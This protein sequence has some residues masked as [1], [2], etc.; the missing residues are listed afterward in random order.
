MTTFGSRRTAPPLHRSCTAFAVLALGAAAAV[1][2]RAEDSPLPRQ[3]DANISALEGKVVAW[4]RDMHQHPELGNREFRTSRLVADHLR[5]L[6]MEVSTGVAHTGVVALLRGGRPGPVVLLRA[7]MDALPVTE[8]ARVPFAS[9]AR[10]EYNGQE[11]GVMHACGHDAHVA[12]LMGVAEVLAGYRGELPGTIK[13]VFQ[14][15]E[16]G[17]PFGEE[18]GAGLMVKEGVLENPTVHAAFALHIWS[19]AEVGHIQYASG[20]MWASSDD[21]R[22]LVKGRQ[23]HGAYPWNGADPIVAA[24]HIVTALQT[25]VSREVR[26]TDSPAVVSIGK[27]QGGVRYN[28]IPEQVEMVG[29]IRALAPEHRQQLHTSVRRIAT[30]VARALGVTADISL[31]YTRGLPVTQNAP[32][33]TK[34]MVPVLESI[35][36]AERVHEIKPETGGEDFGF[37]AERVPGF[38]IRIGGRARDTTETDAPA[39]HTPEFFIDDSGLHVGVRALTA[40]ALQY[41]RTHPL[42]R[43]DTPRTKTSQ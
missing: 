26:L 2:A 14:P 1:A 23:T 19:R 34:A 10:T 21:F 22:I 42:S 20:G 30:D 37:I 6:G 3:V 11:V 18:G 33:L 8:R 39:H 7:D 5:S 13:F 15:S 17:A 38:Y 27:I 24:A 36:G 41:M 29:T 43:L 4:R 35:V 25:I 16:E 9:A 31:P 28:I 12:V 40:M 32:E